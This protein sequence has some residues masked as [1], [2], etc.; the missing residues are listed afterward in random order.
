MKGGVKRFGEA[1]G[2]GGELAGVAAGAQ[3]D[4]A[5]G[6]VAG[7]QRAEGRQASPRMRELVEMLY[8]LEAPFEVDDSKF[9]AAFGVSATP[10]E[11]AVAET[12]AWVRRR[13][14]AAA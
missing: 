12:A 13:F 10:V 6:D 1:G 7:E 8:Q 4:A 3:D 2:G 9:R 14:S 5:A 11:E